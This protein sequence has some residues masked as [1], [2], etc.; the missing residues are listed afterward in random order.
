LSY[1]ATSPYL[2]ANPS[3]YFVRTALDDASQAPAIASLVKLFGWRQVVPI[4]EDSDFGRGFI[5]SLVDALQ[6]IDAR[7]PY[8]SVI[9]SVPT[10]DQIKAEINKLKTMQTRV[11]IVHM[12]SDIAARLFFIAHEAEMLVDGYAWI[13]TDSVG[14]M[15]SS[16]DQNTINS[17]QGVL[18]LRPYVPPS[19]KLLH[20]PARF[21]SQY[22]RE[23]PG[24]PYPANPNVF[25]FWAYDTAWAIATALRR[26]GSLTLGFQML[27]QQNSNSSNDLSMLS[28]SQD[29]PTLIDAI[30]STRFQGISGDFAL[31][32]G[33]RHP[34]AFEI[35]NVIGNSYQ[36][37]GFWTLKSGLSTSLTT[38]PSATGSLKTVIWPGGSVLP[39]KGWEWPVTGKRLRIAV[40]VKPFS[41][42]FV[43]VNKDETTGK[44]EVTGY[45]ID[46]FEAV[47]QEMPYAVPFVYVPVDISGN[48]SSPYSEI[49]KQV[50]VKVSRAI[51]I[52]KCALMFR[53]APDL[54]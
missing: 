16:L 1:T 27:S 50:S 3:K 52:L 24:A 41:N 26:T 42:P 49:C 54:I 33:Q 6:N 13:V 8:R 48:M 53:Q 38:A 20:F 36:T 35:I 19:D 31:L 43:N 21:V 34:F 44:F 7:I 4:Y 30:R 17:M 25:Q 29:G 11:F 39:P 51:C 14:N 23:N 45:C 37:A 28:V 32:N 18:G 46:I 2:S 47:M 12:S 5:P 15:F 9:P 22:L 10:D 40:P